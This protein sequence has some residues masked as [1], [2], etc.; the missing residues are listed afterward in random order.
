MGWCSGPEPS[1][2]Y[3]PQHIP[4][5]TTPTAPVPVAAEGNLYDDGAGGAGGGGG[6]AG[7]GGGESPQSRLPFFQVGSS[8]RASR[9]VMACA[10]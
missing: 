8:P 4:T 2:T 7:G 9:D 5:L 3:T 6:G 10:N 1:I